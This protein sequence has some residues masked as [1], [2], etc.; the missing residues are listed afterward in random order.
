MSILVTREAT[1]WTYRVRCHEPSCHRWQRDGH[2]YYS[3]LVADYPTQDEAM[4]A[5]RKHRSDAHDARGN[6]ELEIRLV[7]R[8]T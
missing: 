1:G 5:A 6:A 4:K 2:G 8:Q 7:R 3:T